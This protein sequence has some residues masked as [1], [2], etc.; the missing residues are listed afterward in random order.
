MKIELYSLAKNAQFEVESVTVQTP[1]GSCMI[2]PGHA[3]M[4]APLLPQQSIELILTNG[5]QKRIFVL[6]GVIQITRVLVTLLVTEWHE[7]DHRPSD[8][9]IVV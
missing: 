8:S 6:Q 5:L 2:Y 9:R 1:A 4:I 7:E 3:P